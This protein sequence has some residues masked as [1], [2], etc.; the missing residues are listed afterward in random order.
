MS[1]I[2]LRLCAYNC[3]IDKWF[4]VRESVP[5]RKAYLVT[6]GNSL[7][8]TGGSQ[9]TSQGSREYLGSV[10]FYDPRKD[11]W[12]ESTPLKHKHFNCAACFYNNDL[13]VSG[14]EYFSY[15]SGC[16]EVL[17]Y[18]DSY[19]SSTVISS[20]PKRK[21]GHFLIPYQSSLWAVGGDYNDLSICIYNPD[22][23]SWFDTK[24]LLSDAVSQR[25]NVQNARVLDAFV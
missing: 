9:N 25:S 10:L 18:S 24:N 2:H 19:I 8:L 21:Q 20:M 14:G 1:Q 7:Y 11:E 16:S 4:T 3:E 12:I 6:N 5:S 22:L 13:F 23:N 15:F 17:R